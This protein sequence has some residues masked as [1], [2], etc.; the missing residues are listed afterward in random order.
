MTGPRSPLLA[1]R[2]SRAVYLRDR[3]PTPADIQEA[4]CANLTRAEF[5]AAYAN[6]F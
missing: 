5:I 2:P 1:H 6:L 3:W 4:V